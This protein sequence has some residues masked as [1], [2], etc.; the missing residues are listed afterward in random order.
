MSNFTT[1][2]HLSR[3]TFLRASGVALALTWL[4]AMMPAFGADPKPTMRFVG[5]LN[6]FS[7]H[8]PFLF[9]AESGRDYKSNAYLDALQEHR[10]DFSIISGM[11]HPDVSG[12]HSGDLSF[13]TGAPCPTSPTFKNTISLDQ[14]IGESVGR[15]T[16][17]PALCLTTNAGRGSCSYTRNGVTLPAESSAERLFAKLFINGTPEEVA[18]EVKRLQQGKSILD[19]LLEKA[20]RLQRE[21]GARDKE[22]L[23]QYFTSV[24][25]LEQRLQ[26]NQEY[27]RMPKPKPNS[28]PIKDPAPGEDTVR[29]GLLLEVSR[30]ALQADLTRS[31]S[32]H[33]GGTTKTPSDPQTS[34]SH[35]D[36]THHGQS[37]DKLEILARLERDLLVEWG[38]FLKRL[39]DTKDDDARLMDHTMSVLGAAMGSANLHHNANLPILLAGGRFAHGQHLAFDPATPPPLC[40]LWLQILNEMGGEAAKFG[41][42]TASTVPGL[43]A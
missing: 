36:C 27:A 13:F 39:K 4:D 15:T 31:V 32:I 26:Q 22:K 10:E 40:N 30:L 14:A 20:T 38:G 35:H 25:E 16:R 2:Q 12:G 43:L 29:L 3:R 41:S 11:S 7:F 21:V 1:Q 5:I 19:R 28:P 23:D 24:R 42:S 17:Y 34:Y 8:T 9:P 6:I 18:Q 33:Y 37:P